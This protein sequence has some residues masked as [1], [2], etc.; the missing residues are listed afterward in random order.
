MASDSDDYDALCEFL[1]FNSGF[2]PCTSSIDESRNL[3][4]DDTDNAINSHKEK[5]EVQY[6]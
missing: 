6:I 4:G 3:I 2:N 1:T 5:Q